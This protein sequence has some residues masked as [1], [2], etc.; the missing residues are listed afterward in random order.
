MKAVDA[1]QRQPDPRDARRVDSIPRS[2]LNVRISRKHHVFPVS[3]AAR[4]S[5]PTSVL[6]ARGGICVFNAGIL[7]SREPQPI[8]GGQ[9]PMFGIF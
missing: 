1:A 3:G 8:E 4:E 7:I 9:W 6:A 2:P 5:P